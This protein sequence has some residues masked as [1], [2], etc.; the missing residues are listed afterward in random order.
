MV[1]PNPTPLGQRTTPFSHFSEDVSLDT[2]N[3]AFP[4]NSM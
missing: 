2:G 1:T 4:L 3:E